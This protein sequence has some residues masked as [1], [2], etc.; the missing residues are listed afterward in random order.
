MKKYTV[1]YESLS[2]YKYN[3][4]AEC[5][6]HF[7]LTFPTFSLLWISQSLFHVFLSW[8][9][10]PFIFLDIKSSLTV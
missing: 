1:I 5:V 8:A 2:N 9:H 4:F 10:S 7:V 3:E 6:F